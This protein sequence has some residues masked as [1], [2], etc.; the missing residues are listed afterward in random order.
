MDR[1][2]QKRKVSKSR[3]VPSEDLRRPCQLSGDFAF[4]IVLADDPDQG[5]Q[6]VAARI[7]ERRPMR[8]GAA[9]ATIRSCVMRPCHQPAGISRTCD[10]V[11]QLGGTV[12]QPLADRQSR[13]DQ[14]RRFDRA[15]AADVPVLEARDDTILDRISAG[16]KDDRNRFYGVVSHVAETVLQ[17]AG[18][19]A[20]ARHFATTSSRAA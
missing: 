15:E 19:R 7:G 8:R 9:V 11:C 6:A 20:A 16:D 12:M 14:W 3:L 5:E 1:R 13:G 17:T 10:A 2:W 4:E 18:W